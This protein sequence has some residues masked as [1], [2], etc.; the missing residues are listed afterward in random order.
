VLGL[1]LITRHRAVISATTAIGALG[2]S[3]LVTA[4]AHAVGAPTGLTQADRNSSTHVLSWSPV[5]K[6]TSYEVQVDADPSFDSP[7]YSATTVNTRIVPGSLLRSGQEFWRVRAI[8]GSTRSAWA[9]S[10][11]GVAPVAS[12]VPLAPADDEDLP[13][14]DAPPLVHWSAVQG[15][16]SYTVLVDSE[17]DMIGAKTYTTKGTSLVVPD[18]L[19]VGAWYWQVT[20]TK[21]SGQSSLPSDQRSF[22]IEALDPPQI[23]YPDDNV[24]LSKVEDVVLDWKP[25]PGATTYDVQVALDQDF[26]NIALS[27]TNVR[28]SRYSPAT[29]LNND[30]FWWRVRAVD[31][32]GQQTPWT[33]TLYGFKRE[34]LESVTPVYPLG[35]TDNPSAISGTKAYYQWTPVIHASEYQLQVSTDANF[36]PAVTTT[37]VTAHTTYTPRNAGDC[38]FPSGSTIRYWRVRP[39]DYPY[40]GGLPGIY[41]QAQAFTYTLPPPPS[42]S[43]DPTVQVT[44]L[45]I[46]I[47][48]TGA[49]TGQGCVGQTIDD[50]CTDLPATPTLSW[51]PVP[52]AG[53]YMV[54]YGQDANFTTSTIP[55][56]PVTTNTVF[57]LNTGNSKNSLPD[58]QAG[59]AYFWHIRPC[60]TTALTTCAPDPVSN[61]SPL[62]DT[63]SFKKASPAIQGLGTSNPN[64]S[65]VTFSWDD[66]YDTNRATTWHGEKSNQTA[67]QYRIQ[68]D[69]DPSFGTPIDTQLVDQTTY[70]EWNKLYADGEYWWR[71]QAVDDANQG[72]TW[73]TS[74]KFTKLSPAVDLTSPIGAAHVEGTTPFRWAAAPFAASYQLEVYKDNDLAFSPANRVLTATVKTTAYVP[75]TPLPSSSTNY[76]WRVRRLDASGNPGP[77]SAVGSF[78]S[79]GAAASLVAPADG[80]WTQAARSLFEW[81]EVPG[82]TSYQLLIKGDATMT[83]TTAATAYAP[84]TR[85]PDGSFTWRVVALDSSGRPL[86]TSGARS[87][88]VDGTAPQVASVTPATLKPKS[89]IKA[90]FS[91][92]VSAVSGKT[93]KLYRVAHKKKH[94]IAAVVS[95]A[96]K[97]KVAKLDPKRPLKSGHYLL[98]FKST[99]IKDRAGNQLV[100]SSVTPALT[101]TLSQG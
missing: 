42:G 94:V 9:Q 21:G 25:V 1:R 52:G 28:S 77:W 35:A 30:Q 66:Y 20:A 27:V 22:R 73:S 32:A 92:R 7:E 56:V 83:F 44:G 45:K 60:T 86:G 26:N 71:V 76:V 17:R 55:S 33:S 67:R 31:A 97:G 6:A 65:E 50:T 12:P 90:T 8:V 82:A 5:S 100:P 96:K 34:W 75:Q 24:V 40:G 58:S 62:P 69:D 88:R 93:M 11:F 29:T 53:A 91:E 51:D 74:Q 14:P 99:K 10:S 23:T 81:T 39:M 49:T 89:V 37:C 85:L 101:A 57:Q 4:P 38:G 84:M 46:G 47:D 59:T 48:G 63:R 2:I 54:Y 36:S 87:F 79:T 15:A 3:L 64:S 19:T 43:W 41:S 16:T 70:T 72:Q 18:P 13:Q 61:G 98:V 95:S 68:V 80:V 78:Y